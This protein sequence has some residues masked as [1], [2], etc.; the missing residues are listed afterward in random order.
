MSTSSGERKPIEEIVRD[1]FFAFLKAVS[2]GHRFDR[3]HLHLGHSY[4]R[5]CLLLGWS[6][7]PYREAIK[8]TNEVRPRVAEK[9]IQRLL[10][11]SMVKLFHEHN[12][13]EEADP[14]ADAPL[15]DSILDTLDPQTVNNAVTNLLEL[16]KS[17]IEP[18]TAYVF[19]EGIK[20]KGLRELKLGAATLYP[21]EYGPLLQALE[22]AKTQEGFKSA[23]Q[24][25]EGD[26]EHCHCYLTVDIEGESGFV[27]EQALRQTP[28][29]L[30]IL[31]LYLGS[32]R[33]RTYQRIGVLGQPTVARHRFV[34]AQTPPIGEDWSMT[35]FSYSREFA[36]ARFYEIDEEMVQNWK[37]HGLDKVVECI[38][39]VDCNSGSVESRMRRAVIWYSRAL[40]AYSEDEQFVGLATA[41]ESLLVAD[42]NIDSITQRLA[43][44]V[45][46]LLGG[47]FQNRQCIKKQMKDLYN[48][49]GRVVHAGMP[50]SQENLFSLDGIVA[51]TI[52]AFIGREMTNH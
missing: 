30:S 7:Q 29:I 20:L 21:K 10:T 9:T 4:G 44:E 14:E 48:L 8:V 42:D 39:S 49:R 36:P 15:L 41:L 24:R 23:L 34:F 47:D 43:D 1:K 16:L 2:L 38:E 50:V 13:S 25:I 22:V 32:S 46:M 12:V 19:V 52:I 37:Q 40:N 51:N 35:K 33:H 3:D 18:W 45:S 17:R 31:N 11:Q 27:R 28:D 26:T 5:N 6:D